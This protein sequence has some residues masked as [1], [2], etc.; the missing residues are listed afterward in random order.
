MCL[1]VFLQQNLQTIIAR[2]KPQQQSA[3]AGLLT[4]GAGRSADYDT[5]RG[6]EPYGGMDAMGKPREL[7][8]GDW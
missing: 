6:T 1:C 7:Q 5:Q 4:P 2:I 8:K 3:L